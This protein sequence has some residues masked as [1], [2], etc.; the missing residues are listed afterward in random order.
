M[1]K[2][3]LTDLDVSRIRQMWQWL[4][5][6]SGV[7]RTP[8][9]LAVAHAPE[10]RPPQPPPAPTNIY[11]VVVS[12][13][14]TKGGVYSGYIFNPPAA[15]LTLDP[16]ASGTVSSSTI[17]SQGTNI[18]IVNLAEV[19]KNTHDLTNTTRYRVGIY[20]ARPAPHIAAYNGLNF[21]EIDG[22][23]EQNCS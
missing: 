13:A 1:A 20:F 2:Y 16:T 18:Y 8:Y 17:G 9:G 14:A 15:T 6:F 21:Y 3:D 10:R 19:S 7:T 11:R 22:I 23:D 4:T 12:A 5:H